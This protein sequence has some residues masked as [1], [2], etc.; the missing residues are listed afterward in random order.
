M[1]PGERFS[2][3]TSAGSENFLE[4][5]SPS[6]SRSRPVPVPTSRLSLPARPVGAVETIAQPGVDGKRIKYH[7]AQSSEQGSDTEPA[8]AA[9]DVGASSR[10][11]QAAQPVTSARDAE[12][13]AIRSS[14]AIPWIRLESLSAPDTVASEHLIWF[15]GDQVIKAMRIKG[16]MK[17]SIPLKRSEQNCREGT[18]SDGAASER[19]V[20]FPTRS[21]Y[22]IL[23]GRQIIPSARGA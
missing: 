21:R 19:H 18:P 22:P 8:Q 10:A 6:K 13:Q 3:R 23:G 7:L 20:G 11:I 1:N 14:D 17:E 16:A 5:K 12:L 9:R 15:K 2:R 4:K